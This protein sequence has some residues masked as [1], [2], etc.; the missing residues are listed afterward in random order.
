VP[1]VADLKDVMV[2]NTELCNVAGQGITFDVFYQGLKEEIRE[3]NER[4]TSVDRESDPIPGL[5]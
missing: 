1:S 5:V 2:Y 3:S 4:I